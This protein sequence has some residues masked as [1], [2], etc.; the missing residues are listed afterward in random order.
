[1]TENARS[2]KTGAPALK[3]IDQL[4]LAV[5]A[6]LAML[7]GM[8]LDLFSQLAAG[9]READEIAQALGVETSRLSRLLY[10][11]AAAGLLERSA[12]GF[13]NGHEA[14]TYFVKG[15]PRYV[16]NMH[17]LL[18]QL[19]RADFETARSIRS[20]EPAAL[21]DYSEASD[22]E[23]SAILRGLHPLALNAGRDLARRFDF[24]RSGSVVD[25][26]GGSGG[27]I[28]TL[29]DLNPNMAGVLY[30]LART[31]RL[32]EPLLRA[33]PGGERVAIEVGDILVAPPKGSHDAVILR[34]LVQVLG[35]GDGERAIGNAAGALR[36]GGA[37]YVC[38][39]I[40]DDDRLSPPAAASLNV[41]FM[42]VYR[43]GASYTE[44]EHARWLDAAG[45]GDMRRITLP[46]GSGIISAVK[47]G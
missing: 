3:L 37:I 12:V 31:A 35:P 47:R 22:D 43:S 38:G 19:W 39:S 5:P 41:T 25:I 2:P 42:N 33:T 34:A 23:M 45:C 4:Q 20:G 7:A 32:A 29:C 30:D 1:M 9:P 17:E 27:V 16:G 14:A 8:K 40:L 26:G 11:L 28:A 24:S 18:D 21:H 36:P 15:S 44:G 6:A 46:N 10:A 13:A